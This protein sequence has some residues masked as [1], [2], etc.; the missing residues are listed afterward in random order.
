[1][2]RGQD[3]RAAE[4]REVSADVLPEP[5]AVDRVRR[6]GG[7]VA[8][9]Q[10]RHEVT[11][12]GP[13]GQPVETGAV[14]Q[15]VLEPVDVEAA[16]AQQVQQHPG[17]EVTGPGAHHQA[18]QR[19]VH[20]AAAPD[21][22][23][24]GAVAEV[25]PDEVEVGPVVDRGRQPP[26]DVVVAGAVHAVPADARAGRISASRAYV[27]ASGGRPT[28]QAVSKTAT[29]GTSRKE[30]P[31]LPDALDRRRVVERERGLRRGP[32]S[33]SGPRR[34]RVPGRVKL[35]SRRARPDDRPRRGRRPRCPRRGR[36]RQSRA[37][38]AGMPSVPIRSR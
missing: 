15:Q 18:L 19:G 30:S 37:T 2:C 12:V 38:R 20:G 3:V 33:R 35:R 13:A 7:L 4:H 31:G 29:C 17:V 24:G 34:R 9:V 25:E 16:L 36:R 14:V 21:G 8:R 32:R 23:G 11:E 1:M 28:K 27:A 6:R 22:G 10:G 26:G 5:V